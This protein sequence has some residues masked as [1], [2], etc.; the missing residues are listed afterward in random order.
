MARKLLLKGFV[1]DVLLS[2]GQLQEAGLL[3]RTLEK[4]ERMSPDRDQDLP[5]S[6]E[7][8]RNQKYVSM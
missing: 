1:M 6:V 4:I 7:G 2:E 8:G 3:K 5:F